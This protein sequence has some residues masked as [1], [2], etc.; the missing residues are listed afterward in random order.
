MFIMMQQAAI[1]APN[2]I[3]NFHNY[4]LIVKFVQYFSFKTPNQCSQALVITYE[5]NEWRNNPATR[6]T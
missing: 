1:S 5:F 4:E 6:L 2:L 3:K